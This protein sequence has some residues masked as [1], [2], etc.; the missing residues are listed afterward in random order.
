MKFTLH[1]PERSHGIRVIETIPD[2][3]LCRVEGLNGIG[4]TLA[5]HLLELCTGQQPYRTRPDA[6]RTLCQYLGPAEVVVEGLRGERR[7]GS[8][9]G[10]DDSAARHTLRFA[11]DW[12]DRAELPV[13]LE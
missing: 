1:T 2:H 13:P 5:L 12:R 7:D 9:G 10:S 4:K 11:F 8:G 6:W 3:P